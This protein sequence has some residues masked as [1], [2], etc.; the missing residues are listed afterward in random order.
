[1]LAAA[2]AL[3][4]LVEPFRIVEGVDVLAAREGDAPLRLA[5]VDEVQMG[6]APP[7]YLHQPSSDVIPFHPTLEPRGTTLTVRGRPLHTGRPVV[8][9][10]GTAAVPFVDDGAG[11]VV[12]R[13]TV[14]DSMTLWIAAEFGDPRIGVRIRQPDEQQVLSIPDE[15]PRVT[16]EG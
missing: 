1:G 15:A 12:A 14:A 3:L 13:W 4:V 7:E 10:D 11:H 6:A 8:L 16:V 2:G 5:W 9:T